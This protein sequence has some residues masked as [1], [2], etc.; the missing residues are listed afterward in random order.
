[1]R[2]EVV[3]KI[4]RALALIFL[5]PFRG[6]QPRTRE[7]QGESPTAAEDVRRTATA[8]PALGFVERVVGPL[9]QRG[10]DLPVAAFRIEQPHGVEPFIAR[11]G[12]QETRFLRRASAAAHPRA[13]RYIHHSPYQAD[14]A[15]ARPRAQLADLHGPREADLLWRQGQR[16]QG[17]HFAAAAIMVAPAGLLR[18]RRR[19]GKRAAL[20]V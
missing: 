8:N 20:A 18:R 3:L 12:D 15:A 2:G 6:A 7:P 11:A 4:A 17:P 5:V 9:G 13:Q 19:R 16:G 1:V 10:C 14:S